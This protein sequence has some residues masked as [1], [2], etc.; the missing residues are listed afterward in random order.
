[1]RFLRPLKNLLKYQKWQNI[2]WHGWHQDTWQMKEKHNIH[3]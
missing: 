1:M 3:A 2:Y